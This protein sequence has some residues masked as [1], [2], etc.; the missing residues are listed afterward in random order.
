MSPTGGSSTS[1]IVD[2]TYYINPDGSVSLIERDED[3]G[4]VVTVGEVQ[5]GAEVATIAEYEARLVEIEAAVTDYVASIVAEAEAEQV[6]ID[7]QRDAELAKIAAAAG[8]TVEALREA[9]T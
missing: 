2:T 3:A 4:S 7:E 8:T 1:S 5:E 6:A 9:L